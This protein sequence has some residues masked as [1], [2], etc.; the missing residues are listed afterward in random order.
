MFAISRQITGTPRLAIIS[1]MVFFIVGLILL[2]F[3]DE[4]K[5]KEAKLS[6][7]F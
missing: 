7:A 4:E 2:A 6:G 3:V 5:A 1:L